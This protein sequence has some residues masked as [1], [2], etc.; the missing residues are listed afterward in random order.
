MLHQLK[1]RVA[2][3]AKQLSHGLAFLAMAYLWSEEYQAREE[4]Y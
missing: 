2:N 4:D 1:S 3:L